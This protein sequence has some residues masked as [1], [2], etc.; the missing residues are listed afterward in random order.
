MQSEF[1][2]MWNTFKLTESSEFSKRV[3]LENKLKIMDQTLGPLYR[4]MELLSFFE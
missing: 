3:L 1:A 4:F 2:G